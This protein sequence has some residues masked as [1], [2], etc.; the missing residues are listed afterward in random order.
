LTKK[1]FIRWGGFA[2]ILWALHLL[3]RDFT[4][5]FTHG[6]TEADMDLTFLGLNSLQYAR[7]WTAFGL[8]GLIGLAGVY[9]QVS[10]RLSKTGKA[11][12]WVALL[13]LALWF[14]AQVMQVWILDPDAN[15]HSP[16]VFGGW[17]LSVASYFVL[18]AGLVLAGID[19]QRANALPRARSLIL[20]MGILLVPTV[21]LVGYIVGHSDDSLPWKLLYGGISVPYDLCWLWLGVLL[22]AG[23]PGISD[24]SK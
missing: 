8:L 18:A 24:S 12:F 6:S 9:V 23:T 15:F 5:A 4:F 10:P 17:L 1:T 20:I 21:L 22:L 7:L 14:T 13:G 2:L 11:G 16:L 3:A 19:I